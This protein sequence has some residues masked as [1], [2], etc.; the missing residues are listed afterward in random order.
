MSAPVRVGEW[1]VRIAP[2]SLY[3]AG[4]DPYVE[5]D[6]EYAARLIRLGFVHLYRR[7]RYTYGPVT[8]A[9]IAWRDLRW[10]RNVTQPAEDGVL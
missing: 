4:R 1:S 6:H 9:R 8:A 5:P 7:W 2:C 3:P 10:A